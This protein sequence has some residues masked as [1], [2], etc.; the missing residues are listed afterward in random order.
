MFVR[1]HEGVCAPVCTCV[2]AHKHACGGQRTALGVVAFFRYPLFE[3]FDAHWP[4]ILP[5]RLD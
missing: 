1:D 4:R 5:T 2:C 3:I